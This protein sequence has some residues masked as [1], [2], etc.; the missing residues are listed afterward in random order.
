MS[1]FLRPL[2]VLVAL[3]ACALATAAGAQAFERPFIGS[4]QKISSIGSTV[5]TNGDQN[6]YGI[7]NVQ[8]STGSLMAGD[9]LI[10]NF[11]DAGSPPT[12][13]LQGTGTTIVQ[14]SPSGHLSLF[15]QIDPTSLPGPCP[16]G[17]GLTTALAILP[18]GYVVVGSLPTSNGLAATAQAG[19]LIVLDSRGHVVET[20]SGPPKPHRRGH[21]RA[22]PAHPAGRRRGDDRQGRLSQQPAGPDHRAERGR[23]HGQRQ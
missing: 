13:N 23:A 21:G 1:K 20:I 12:G 8:A 5:P 4:L 22:Q 3:I 2:G 7:V 18:P 15:A 11:N 14:M 10:S 17:V 19:C 6:P 16:G 9:I